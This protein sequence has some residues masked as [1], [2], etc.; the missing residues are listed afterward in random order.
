MFVAT[1]MLFVP[2]KNST[3]ATASVKCAVVAQTVMSDGATKIEPSPGVTIRTEGVVFVAQSGTGAGI[4]GNARPEMEP[5]NA[6]RTEVP[7]HK[8]VFMVV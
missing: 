5:I 3:L 6:Q 7:K 2:A 1:P 8:Y 4:I